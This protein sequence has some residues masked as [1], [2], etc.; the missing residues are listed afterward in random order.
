M[1][2]YVNE[3][4]V[5]K[6]GVSKM[7]VD[8][9]VAIPMEESVEALLD[10][11]VEPYLSHE[12]RKTK[13][14]TPSISQQK[15]IAKQV[16]AVVLLYNYYLRKSQQSLRYL[17][18][19][20]FCKLAVVLKPNLMVYMKL[21]REAKYSKVEDLENHLSETEKSI[22]DACNISLALDASKQV[23]SCESWPISKVAILLTDAGKEKCLLFHG[24]VTESAWSFVEKNIDVIDMNPEDK[25]GG[26]LVYRRMKLTKNRTTTD[27][28]AHDVRLQKVVFSA[29]E[30]A[31]GISQDDLLVL[32]THNAYSLS[33]EKTA[34]RFYILQCAQPSSGDFQISVK[35]VVDSLQGSLVKKKSSGW[36]VSPAVEYFHILPYVGILLDWLSRKG[37]EDL[38][39]RSGIEHHNN[40]PLEVDSYT[41]EISDK[42]CVSSKA[43]AAN[44]AINKTSNQ[45]EES[46]QRKDLNECQVDR[47]SNKVGEPCDMEIDDLQISC[48]RSSKSR[49]KFYDQ[50]QNMTPSDSHE[51]ASQSD[52]LAE[53]DKDNLKSRIPVP[54]DERRE[55][56]KQCSIGLLVPSENNEILPVGLNSENEERLSLASK[57]DALSQ[58]ALKILL[59][60]REK[61]CHQL[62]SIE[63]ELASCNKAIQ[64]MLQGAKD[65]HPQTPNA[66]LIS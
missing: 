59:K 31:A 2:V 38:A 54:E 61:L 41:T 49:A 63:D 60:T 21:M 24:T 62:H 33:K 13:T 34:A 55:F 66:H 35:E 15:L 64:L 29:I 50:Q 36:V 23:P 22:M 45:I 47:P 30:E 37:L 10:Y 27:Q 18:M 58:T 39:V 12:D 20:S 57:D 4:L 9:E 51:H 28:N 11:F 3:L 8:A 53:P 5:E 1:N 32:E 52:I 16:H 46:I 56:G 6:S 25:I 43:F 19:E 7:E 42:K 65:V 26:N 14:A 40:S 17:N 48:S 44:T